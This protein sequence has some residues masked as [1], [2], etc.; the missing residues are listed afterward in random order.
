LFQKL[1]VE[2]QACKWKKEVLEDAEKVLKELLPLV[3]L[4]LGLDKTL[5]AIAVIVS[6]ILVKCGIT[7]FC[8]CPPAE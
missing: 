5:V 3:F 2:G 7:K 6:V 8:E 1:C 4:A